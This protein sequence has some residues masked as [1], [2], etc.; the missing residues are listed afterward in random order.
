ML[1][2]KKPLAHSFQYSLLS[3][4]FASPGLKVIITILI[5]TRP[6]L[7]RLHSRGDILGHICSYTWV[8]H[9]SGR[10]N[11]IETKFRILTYLLLQIARPGLVM[12]ASICL[13]FLAS[14]LLSVLG[15]SSSALL[16]TGTGLLGVGMASIFA[17][18]FLWTEQRITVT[19]KVSCTWHCK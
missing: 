12:W 1:E 7:L 18:G 10:G 19:S 3:P 16:F 17:T 13:C 9:S 11:M 8:S 15:A 2:W 6:F 4:V 5:I 14:L